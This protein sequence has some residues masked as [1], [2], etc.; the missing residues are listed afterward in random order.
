M[1]CASKTGFGPPTPRTFPAYRSKV[2]TLLQF[3]IVC[4][5]VFQ[6]WNSS[7]YYLFSV[8]PAFG[9]SGRL[10]FV[11]VAFPGYFHLYKYLSYL[12]DK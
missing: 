8:S 2:V 1:M 11:I 9:A 3:F 10:C 5:P 4:V 6:M 7:C 12:T